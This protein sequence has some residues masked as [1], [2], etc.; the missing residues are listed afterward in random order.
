MPTNLSQTAAASSVGKRLIVHSFKGRYSGIN[1]A[2]RSLAEGRDD[3]WLN[4]FMNSKP[5]D[6]GLHLIFRHEPDEENADTELWADAQ[7]HFRDL[8]DQ[9][10][11]RGA[12][13]GWTEPILFGANFM[14][15]SAR[16]NPARIERL[17]EGMEEL[18][19]F[20]S[21]DGY[22]EVIP[23]DT[24]EHIFGKCILFNQAHA[25]LPFAIGEFGQDGTPNTDREA[26]ILDVCEYAHDNGAL[27]V[28]YWNAIIGDNNYVLG[29]DDERVLGAQ[30]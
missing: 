22:S 25:N 13:N 5:A 3:S 19:D 18:W 20:I 24:A 10:N 7:E 28:H 1:D 16:T 26:F 6:Q 14:S 23:S 30:S 8:V 11:A 2:C 17:A 27:W 29:P 15:Y 9:A 4:S 12:D 21:W